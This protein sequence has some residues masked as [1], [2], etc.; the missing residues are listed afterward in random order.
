MRQLIVRTLVTN[1]GTSVLG[2]INA[3]LLSRWLGPSGRG[4]IAAALLW[5]G[6]LIYLG[7]MGL[8]LA[9]MYFSSLPGANASVVLGNSLWLGVLLSCFAIAIGLVAMPWLLHS[10]LLAVV[11]ASRWYLLVIPLS[12]FSQF[13]ISV[14]QARLRLKALNWLNAVIPAGYLLGTIV[15]MG[16]GKLVL[17]NIVQLH[18]CLNLLVLICTFITLART[19]IYPNFKIDPLLAKSILAYGAKVHVGQVS[20]FAN[21]NLDQALIA[22]WLPP[23]ALGLYVVAVTSAGMFQIFSA[24]VQTV[25][26]PS[27]ARQDTAEARRRVFERVFSRY[28]LLSIL[29]FLALAAV[30]PLAIPLIYGDAFRLSLIPAEILLLGALFMGARTL[31]TSGVAALGDP[32]L[33]SKAS[34]IALPVTLVLLYLLLPSLGLIGAALASTAAYFAEL[35]V[36]VSGCYRRHTISP[37]SLFQLRLNDI[38]SGLQ[39][40]RASLMQKHLKSAAQ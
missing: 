4:E 22:A 33:V 14:L 40:L 12:L 2:L 18:L 19:G 13:G 11:S 3:I 16:L 35:A 32:W 38:Y 21:L 5:P 37:R 24:A 15:L 29:L 36:V 39:R 7:S 28:W 1:L 10:Q 31:L 34:L 8:I 30:L 9:T 20:G 17:I 23:A 25:A 27:I 26:M 6:L